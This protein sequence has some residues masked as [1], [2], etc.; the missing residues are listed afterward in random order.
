MRGDKALR[1]FDPI[2]A[3]NLDKEMKRQGIKVLT[4]A[5][6]KAV[7]RHA[8]GTL[9]L[10][11]D[12]GAVHHGFDQVVMATGRKPLVDPLH[13]AKAGVTTKGAHVE[14]DAFQNTKA[15]GVYALG[16]VT[17]P[18]ELTPTAIAAG[19]RLADRLF[20]NLPESKADYDMVPTVVFSHPPIGTIGLSEPDAKAA[21]GADKVKVYTSTFVN[22][23][24][25]PFQVDPSEKPKTAMKLVCVGP[26]E[27][28]VGLHCIGMGSDELLQGFGVAMKMGATKA[29]FDKCV[30]LHPTAA[31]EF[32][33]MAP[34]GLY[35]APSPPKER[36]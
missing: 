16:D 19:R 4:G 5:A 35:T 18:V 30:A 6:P 31:E 34:W 23:F 25:G 17:G 27:R 33:T 15:P 1:R 2:L 32:V 11:L 20:G 13:L 22:L 10:E 36:P 14:V 26:E 3:D 24:Y 8:D 28:V 9:S 21:H 7:T 12:G 29:D